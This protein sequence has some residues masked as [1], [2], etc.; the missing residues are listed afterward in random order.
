MRISFGRGP[1]RPPS[2]SLLKGLRL[3]LVPVLLCL[4]SAAGAVEP[5]PALQPAGSYVD[6]DPSANHLSTPPGNRARFRRVINASIQKNPDNVSAL[7][8][9]A[10]LF[11]EGGDH[12]R[13]RRDYDAALAAAEPGGPHE[14]HALW[15]RGWAS[16]EMDDYA[17]TLSDWQRAIALHGGEP[18]WAAYSLAL[19]YWTTGQAEL[20]LQWYDAAADADPRWATADG[21]AHRT[22]RWSPPQQARMQAL[23]QAWERR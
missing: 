13:A 21:M 9:R 11:M 1:G 18:F 4:A 23:F 5:L 16:Y 10:Y 8:H 6:D 2:T 3:G 7:S 19:L 15:S 22:R 17:A 12:V 20:A 14:R